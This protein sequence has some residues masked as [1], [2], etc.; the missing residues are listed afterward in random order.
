[1]TRVF[2]ALAAVL[3]SVALS[4]CGKGQGVQTSRPEAPKA[5][6]VSTAPV[7]VRQVQAGFQE[8]GAFLAD[9]RSFAGS[10]IATR[11]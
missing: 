10:I 9:K 7:G 6:V 1:M 2:C 5:I 4:G 11:S 3:I 8:T